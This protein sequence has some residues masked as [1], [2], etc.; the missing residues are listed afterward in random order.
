MRKF[1]NNFDINGNF[2][3]GPTLNN[4]IKNILKKSKFY[5]NKL[6]KFKN[7]KINS[8]IFDKI[9]FTTKKELLDDQ[10]K[11]PPFGSNLTLFLGI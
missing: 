3:Y 9:P 6:K 4:K 11:H 5:K 7:K 1:N 8:E 2:N 10:K